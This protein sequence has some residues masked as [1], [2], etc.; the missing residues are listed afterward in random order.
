MF[1]SPPSMD[2]PGK[3][4]PNLKPRNTTNVQ[5]VSNFGFS[6][7]CLQRT[8]RIADSGGGFI[9]SGESPVSPSRRTVTKKESSKHPAQQDTFYFLLIMLTVIKVI[10]LPRCQQ[11]KIIQI[12]YSHLHL[13]SMTFILSSS[14]N[15]NSITFCH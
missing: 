14:I 12:A 13:N 4:H 11:S 15:C 6:F 7:K 1:F 3:T 8:G 10:E 9:S 5:N 2:V